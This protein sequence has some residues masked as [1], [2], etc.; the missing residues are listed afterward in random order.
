[1]TIEIPALLSTLACVFLVLAI[2]LLSIPFLVI[3]L[4][5]CLL[6]YCVLFK[7]RGVHIDLGKYKPLTEEELLAKLAAHIAESNK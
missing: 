3:G 7:S 6:V 2:A 4:Y 1:M 5:I